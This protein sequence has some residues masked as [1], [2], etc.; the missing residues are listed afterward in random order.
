M[1][2]QVGDTTAAEANEAASSRWLADRSKP[3]PKCSSPIEKTEGCNHMTCKKCKH[4]FCWVCLD[5]WRHHSS[6]TGGYFEC[7]RYKAQEKASALLEKR[8]GSYYSDARELEAV[9]RFLH[10][11]ERY[12]EHLNSL[13]LEEPFLDKARDKMQLLANSVRG[14]EGEDMS[15][16]EEAV[17]E[18]LKCRRVLQA[19]YPFAY[20]LSTKKRR[21][22]ERMQGSLEQATE[23]MAEVVARPHLRKPRSEIIRLTHEARTK[24]RMLLENNTKTQSSQFPRQHMHED[25][26][27]EQEDTDITT[28]LQLLGEERPHFRSH[29]PIP[30]SHD[31]YREHP[32]AEDDDLSRAMELS[33]HEFEADRQLQEDIE[34]AKAESRVA[35]EATPTPITLPPVPMSFD[36]QTTPT[37]SDWIS[38]LNSDYEPNNWPILRLRT[39]PPSPPPTTHTTHTPPSAPPSAY[40]DEWGP[41]IGE[42]EDLEQAI[43]LSLQQQS[44]GTAMM[45]VVGPQVIDSNKL[46][47]DN[48]YGLPPELL[49]LL[50]TKRTGEHV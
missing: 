11:Y 25:T 5:N 42:E 22:F 3:C 20:Y 4:D 44:R 32:A 39:P 46:A 19:T 31:R 38:R 2:P 17:R 30:K 1:R 10:Y 6:L 49:H 27:S 40:N 28:F 18:L 24:R 16:I 41:L 21:E 45:D 29:D 36:N 35:P 48:L 50:D 47:E 12:K 37:D 8:R 15:F 23:M 34:K 13:A 26:D 14:L 7:N 9:S 43:Q 33:R